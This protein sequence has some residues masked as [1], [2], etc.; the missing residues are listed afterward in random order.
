MTG[1]YH[2]AWGEDGERY[3][4][5]SR[6]ALLRQSIVRRWQAERWWIVPRLRGLVFVVW[7]PVWC[8]LNDR[9]C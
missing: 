3:Y 9:D 4:A 7:Y 6:L 2:L 1:G 8:F 5:P